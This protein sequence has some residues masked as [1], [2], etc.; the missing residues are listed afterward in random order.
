MADTMKEAVSTYQRKFEAAA[1]LEEQKRAYAEF[2]K[3][4]TRLQLEELKQRFLDGGQEAHEFEPVGS[5]SLMEAIAVCGSADIPLPRWAADAFSKAIRRVF[6]AE[7]A[8]WDEAFGRPW[9]KRTDFSALRRHMGMMQ[10]IFLRVRTL[11]EDGDRAIDEELFEDVG[12]EFK[13]GRSLCSKLYYQEKR[14]L[15]GLPYAIRL[16][17]EL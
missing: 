5:S 9:P 12:K 8:T 17:Q 13:I 7:I 2:D 16:P 14:R 3:D 6:S 11:H 1:N 10:E 4:W 15:G